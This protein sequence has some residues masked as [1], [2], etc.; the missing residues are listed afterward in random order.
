MNDLPVTD[1]RSNV[2][3]WAV[4]NWR[5]PALAKQ[6]LDALQTEQYDPEFAGQYLQTTYFDTRNFDL[7]KARLGRDRYI[8]IRIRCYAPSEGM[9]TQ[10]R[11][12]SSE[13]PES[14]YAISAKTEDKKFRQMIGSDLAE[15]LLHGRLDISAVSGIIPSDLIGRLADIAQGEP[16]V[17]VVTIGFNRYA[18]EDGIHRLTLDLDIRAD[19]GREFPSHVL[20]QKSTNPD[21]APLIALA[22]RPIKLSKFLWATS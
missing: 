1:L 21:A 6:M 16:L 12:P 5:V 18:V 7:R 2:G 8:V 13:Y 19:N 4:P 15:Y 17:P 14:V 22:I 20:E 9:P 10:T 3:T 11:G